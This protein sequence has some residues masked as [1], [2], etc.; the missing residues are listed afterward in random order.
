[1]STLRSLWLVFAIA[2]LIAA[3][4]QAQNC[5]TPVNL[6]SNGAFESALTGYSSIGSWQF[7]QTLD[8]AIYGTLY[9]TH[10]AVQ[11]P[12][13]APTGS[14]ATNY[15]ASTLNSF[16]INEN[17]AANDTL[18]ISSPLSGYGLYTSGQLHI[19]FDMGWRQAGGSPTTAGTLDINVNGTTYMRIT[20]V[21]GN[22]A[23]SATSQLFSGATLGTSSASSFANSGTGGAF[24]Q[25]NTVHLIVPYSASSMPAISFAM[26]GG[27]GIS[28][29][30]ALDRIY[31]PMCAVTPIATSKSMTVVSDAV[32]SS[33][34]KAI[35]GATIRYCITV[36]N[37]AGNPTVETIN[38]SDTISPLPATYVANSLR[39]N[40]SVAGATCNVDGVAGGSFASG[41]VSATL[42][43]L[44][45][46]QSRTIYFDML[47]Q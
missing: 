47:V 6:N 9:N 16:V 8:P 38:I 36:T 30:F 45:S 20:T 40:G 18:T 17:D 37:P 23:G 27:G 12:A 15:P 13:A 3:P 10:A 14:L 31:V 2:L 35:P 39:I 34:P 1:M 41:T 46:G 19:W 42:T 32:S 29:D 33:N 43:N 4:A 26:S 21:A 22:N 5:T 28:D 7:N 25:W 44:S 11:N 24:S